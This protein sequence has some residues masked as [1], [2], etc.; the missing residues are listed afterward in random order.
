MKRAKGAS[1]GLV[2]QRLGG[3]DLLKWQGSYGA[4]S[5]SPGDLDRVRVYIRRQEEHHRTDSLDALLEETAEYVDSSVQ[6][7]VRS[8]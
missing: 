2:E 5:V 8:M 6:A 3:G 1:S 7:P 4:L